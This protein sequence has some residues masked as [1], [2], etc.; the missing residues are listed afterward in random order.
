MWNDE[1]FNIGLYIKHYTDSA[2]DTINLHE[3]TTRQN[4]Q[5]Q[6]KVN[7]PFAIYITTRSAGQSPT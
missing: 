6:Q 3:T 1:L 4:R 7:R 2:E 5:R